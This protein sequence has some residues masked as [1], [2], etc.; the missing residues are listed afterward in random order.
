MSAFNTSVALNVRD[1]EEEEEGREEEE[2]EEEEGI[3]SERS[4]TSFPLKENTILPSPVGLRLI[5]SS[6]EE[7]EEEEEGSREKDLSS[8]ERRDLESGGGS[9]LSSTP[10]NIAKS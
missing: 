6:E 3:V 9:C 2:E 4:E 7:E 1:V 5:P 10:I 8:S